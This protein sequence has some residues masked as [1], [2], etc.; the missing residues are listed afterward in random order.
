MR[1]DNSQK[2]RSGGFIDEL[3][4]SG[5]RRGLP[6]DGRCHGLGFAHLLRGGL[7][8]VSVFG[9]APTT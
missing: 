8:F 4:Y 2:V 3:A 5:R 1:A 9:M 7:R 6:H